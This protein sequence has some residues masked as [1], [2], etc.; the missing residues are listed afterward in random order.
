MVSCATN[1]AY[2]VCWSMF[3]YQHCGLQQASCADVPL[4]LPVITAGGP[5]IV[6]GPN[7]AVGFRWNCADNFGAVSEG[8]ILADQC[9]DGLCE[10]LRRA[11]LTMHEVTPA[12]LST[13]T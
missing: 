11:G 6:F 2:G 7:C 9:L 13:E 5:S 4:R 8:A 10:S 3:F 12:A 1:A